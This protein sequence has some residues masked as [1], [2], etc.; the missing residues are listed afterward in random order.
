MTK[1]TL[2]KTKF[3]IAMTQKGWKFRE[4][5]HIW[6]RPVGLTQPQAEQHWIDSIVEALECPFEEEKS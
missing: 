2:N 1:H 3:E 4:D 5:Y 6:E